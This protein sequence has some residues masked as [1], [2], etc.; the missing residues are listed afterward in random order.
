MPS[1]GKIPYSTGQRHRFAAV[2]GTSRM[3]ATARISTSVGCAAD[4]EDR[5]TDARLGRGSTEACRHATADDASRSRS[6]DSAGVRV[7]DRNSRAL[8]LRQAAGQL[9]RAGAGGEVQRRSAPIRT[10]QQTRQ[11]AAALSAG[12]SGAG[13][14]AQSAG[15]AQQVLSPRHAAWT[16]DRQGRM[17]RKL[18]VHLYWMW[19]Q[20]CDYGQL[21]KLG[22]YAGEPG[23]PDGEQSITDVMIGHPAPT[24]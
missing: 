23:N 10:H 11:R 24:K 3:S 13:H 2:C 17:A 6:A 15:V 9:Y 22:S 16:E 12:G 20:G 14:G 5:G 19:R 1:I 18:A 7:G 4:A 8:P 21:H